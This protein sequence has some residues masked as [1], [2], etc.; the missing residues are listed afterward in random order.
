MVNILNLFSEHYSAFNYIPEGG[1]L[2][3]DEGVLG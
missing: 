3:A 2:F 1:R